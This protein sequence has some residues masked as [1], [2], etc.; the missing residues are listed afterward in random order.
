MFYDAAP[1]GGLEF[2]ERFGW[3]CECQT[4]PK[5]TGRP[6]EGQ[7]RAVSPNRGNPSGGAYETD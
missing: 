3:I 4:R 1:A 2:P 6:G 5:A 7:Q